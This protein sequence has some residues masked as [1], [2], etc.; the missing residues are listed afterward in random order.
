MQNIVRQWNPWLISA[1]IG[2]PLRPP[3]LEQ[4]PPNPCHW[5]R[6]RW[7]WVSLPPPTPCPEMFSSYPRRAQNGPEPRRLGGIAVD[8]GQGLAVRSVLSRGPFSPNLMTSLKQYG[9]L[10]G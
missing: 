6:E 1:G 9:F 4:E 8:C 5:P 3:A 10:I 2:H 7:I